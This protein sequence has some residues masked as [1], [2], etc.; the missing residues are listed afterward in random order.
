MTQR[1]FPK[2]SAARQ[3]DFLEVN[4]SGRYRMSSAEADSRP[5]PMAV[6]GR[7]QRLIQ[8][9]GSCSMAP[10]PHTNQGHLFHPVYPYLLRHLEFTQPN[11]VW[12]TGITVIRFRKAV[13]H[14][15]ANADCHSCKILSWRLAAGLELFFCSEA[16]NEDLATCGA[17]RIPNTVKGSRF[18]PSG[19]VDLPRAHGVAITMHGKG[20]ALDHMFLHRHWPFLGDEYTFLG[21]A[22]DGAELKSGLQAHITL[23]QHCQP[24]SS[25]AD[26]APDAVYPGGTMSNCAARRVNAGMSTLPIFLNCF[27]TPYPSCHH[28][29]FSDLAPALYLS[30]PMGPQHVTRPRMPRRVPSRVARSVRQPTIEELS[31]GGPAPQAERRAR[32]LLA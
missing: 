5:P 11:R 22:E 31:M 19:R 9:T 26:L 20:L 24:H 15:I 7:I 8:H 3:C 10:D 13:F 28:D 12:A 25:V 4:R 32:R 30:I 16:L 1:D 29:F 2:P 17:T 6:V 27:P 14:L 18:T 23:D 21:P